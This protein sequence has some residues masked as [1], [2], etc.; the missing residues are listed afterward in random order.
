MN[1]SSDYTNGNGTNQN[2]SN[3]DLALS[4]GTATNAFMVAGGVNS[5]RV[6]N[7]TIY[8]NLVPEPGSLG[9]LALG[10]ACLLAR[11]RRA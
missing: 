5:P 1:Y 11:R 3:A 10:T 9:L 4:F 6:W 8:Y 7:G 2:Y